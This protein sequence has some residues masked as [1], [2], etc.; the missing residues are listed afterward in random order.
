MVAVA[1]HQLAVLLHKQGGLQLHDDWKPWFEPGP[2]PDRDPCPTPFVHGWFREH[3]QYPEGAADMVGYWAEGRI[4]GGV[5]LFDRGA[6]GNEEVSISV[7]TDRA[8][9]SKLLADD[10]M[11]LHSAA[12]FIFSR[13]ATTSHF[14]STPLPT[15]RNTSSSPCSQTLRAYVRTSCLSLETWIT[16]YE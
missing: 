7:L 4:L 3:K 2:W 13:T 14:V 11:V 5:V 16:V 8:T 6:S 1:L 10:V 15:S 9:F 12:R